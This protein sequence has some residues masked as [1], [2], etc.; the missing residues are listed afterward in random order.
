MTFGFSMNVSLQET[1]TNLK[2]NH[3]FWLT[4]EVMQML[5]LP[6]FIV[7]CVLISSLS[8]TTSRTEVGGSR[9]S[10]SPPEVPHSL[11]EVAFLNS[12]RTSDSFMFIELVQT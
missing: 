10:F 4:L 12:S 9:Q 2:T 8:V 7:P 5:R 1:R 11:A 6:E 3:G